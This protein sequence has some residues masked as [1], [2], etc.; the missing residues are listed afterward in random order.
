MV[1]GRFFR[2]LVDWLQPVWV[3][4]LAGAAQRHKVHTHW[5]HFKFKAVRDALM[6]LCDWH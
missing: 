1:I 3:Q 4:L 5:L 2:L 6:P